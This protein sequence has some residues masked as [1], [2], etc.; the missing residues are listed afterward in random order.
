MKFRAYIDDSGTKG[1]G[2]LLWLGGLFG[3]VDVLA[4]VETKWERELR[5][6]L[7]LP[8]AYFKA[9]EARDLSG[10]FSWWRH[11][12]RDEKV[13]RLASL[14]DRPDLLMVFSAVELSSHRTME[15]YI[16]NISDA[17][18]HPL[19]QPYLLAFLSVM[20]TIAKE[21]WRL[22]LTQG[23]EV[24]I[25]EQL[26][27]KTAAKEIYQMVL[28]M[29]QRWLR[30]Y[31]PPEPRFRDDKDCILIQA[32]DLLMGNGR[33]VVDK[34]SGWLPI[35]WEHLGA[36]PFSQNHTAE[37]LS[38]LTRDMMAQR[39]GV[40]SDSLRITMWRPPKPGK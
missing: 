19:N 18:R 5:S 37:P 40:P 30:P 23:V 24:I 7:P 33:M 21:A 1:T 8:I 36:S 11:E 3:A 25:D 14:I 17:A 32:A 4:D 6:R 27:L 35:D 31:M 29:N 13:R 12:G 28:G 38:K 39:M 10:E 34:S 16:G 15:S 22:Q 20:T 26:Q 9:D 2:K